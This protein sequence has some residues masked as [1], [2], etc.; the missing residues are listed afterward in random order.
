[1]RGL[2]GTGPP[3]PTL[4]ST[5]PSLLRVQFGIDSTLIRH[6]LP[7]LTLFQTADFGSCPLRFSGTKRESLRDMESPKRRMNIRRNTLEQFEGITHENV[8]FRGKKGQ[9][10]HPNFAT[11]IPMEFIAML[12]APPPR[13]VPL[14]SGGPFAWTIA[15][16]NA[17]FSIPG[18]HI[19]LRSLE[20][21]T[22]QQ[23]PKRLNHS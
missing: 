9:K 11:N 16:P 2:L 1:M 7:D 6:R 23:R 14:Q 15:S 12:S 21:R 13:F 4:E 3:D 19:Q 5:S 17:H 20:S 22:H 8:G 18:V 10:A